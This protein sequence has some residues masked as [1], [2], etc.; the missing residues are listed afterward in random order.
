MPSTSP[1]TPDRLTW[2]LAIATRNRA[3]ALARCLP[4]AATQTRP[5][6]DVAVCDASDDPTPGRDL[7]DRLRSEHPH[8]QWT[9]LPARPGV[10]HQRNAAWRATTGDVVFLI[11]DDAF[12]HPDCAEHLMAVYDADTEQRIASVMANLDHRAPDEPDV[13][14]APPPAASAR[15][16]PS[17]RDKL[18]RLVKDVTDI[19]HPF[20]PYDGD[21]PAHDLPACVRT[22]GLGTAKLVHGCRMTVRRSVLEREPFADHVARPGGEDLDSS[23]RWS[24]HGLLT[25]CFAARLHHQ[26]TPDDRDALPRRSRFSVLNIVASAA[27][28]AHDRPRGRRIT[29]RYFLRRSAV[30]LLHDLKKRDPRLPRTVSAVVGYREA[31]AAFAQPRD[32]V[33]AWHRNAM[34]RHHLTGSAAQ[35]AAAAAT[36]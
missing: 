30:S 10:G 21:F 18:V 28:Y 22:L 5:P 3:T 14:D 11:D 29:R 19:D 13:P 34:R 7:V 16:A 9:H 1:P 24:R 32:R 35:P 12:M 33:W 27:Y 8:I 6:I 25:T 31:H 36:A 17:L 2:S 23:Y 15:R 4:L 26:T 20:P